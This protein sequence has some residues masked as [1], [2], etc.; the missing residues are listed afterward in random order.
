MALHEYLE[1]IKS[2]TLEDNVILDS[3]TKLRKREKE[4]CVMARESFLNKTEDQ[5]RMLIM[6]AGM[7]FF[8]FYFK[9]N[10]GGY[11][12]LVNSNYYGKINNTK[13]VQ[14]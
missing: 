14:L 9:S 10:K 8:D 1:K 7:A 3:L 11:E 12:A 5:N 6:G 4:L 13:L 2:H